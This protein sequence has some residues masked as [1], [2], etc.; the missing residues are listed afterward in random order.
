MWRSRLFYLVGCWILILATIKVIPLLTAIALSE[1][2]SFQS[3]FSS[4]LLTGLIGGSLVLGFRSTE[5]VRTPRLTLLLPVCGTVSLAI[6]AGLP[7][8][9]LLPDQGLWPAFFEGMSLITT[10]GSSAYEG[11]FDN[12]KAISLWRALVVWVG[13]YFAICVTLS[14]L[15]AMNIGGLQLHQSPL[16]YGESEAG[17]PR[18]RSTALTLYPVYFIV[19]VVCGFLLWIGGLDSFEA[20]TLSMATISTAGLFQNYGDGL[21]SLWVQFILAFFMLLS[22][23]NWDIHHA[24]FQRR[25]FRLGADAEFKGTLFLVGVLI[26]IL[27]VSSQSFDIQRI[28]HSL[29]A[30]I[31]AV[32]TTGIMPQDYLDGAT[33]NHLTTGVLLMLAAAIG[34]S[35]V[36]TGGGLK[37]LR[38]IVIYRTGRAE[39]DRL[40]HPHGV[41][42]MSLGAV[43][44][45]KR[46]VEAVWLLLGSFVVV[47]ALG[48]LSLAILGVHFQDALSMSFT[49]LT[50]SG[51]LT[52]VADPLFGGFSGLRDADYIILT[53]LMM[54]G[55]VETSLFLALFAKSLWRG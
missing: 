29:F 13:G 26:L 54:V 43:E 47:L 55:R 12:L 15:T 36:S 49:A 38:A 14:F 4:I 19:T 37:Q 48:A 33:G 50:L 25:S 10:N 53:I 35:V 2:E 44:V 9:F 8:F 6:V 20:L 21:S 39:V 32:S 18:L 23:M 45:Q 28:W 42:G 46:D 5:K 3:L 40:A 52:T 30:A 17:Y 24:R 27:S 51:P 1:K 16:P 22:M 31:S 34:G 41:S 11:S 7:F